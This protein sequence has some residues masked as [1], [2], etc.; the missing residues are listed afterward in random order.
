MKPG[1]KSQIIIL[2]GLK[3][4][5]LL[6]MGIAHGGIIIPLPRPEGLTS[7]NHSQASWKEEKTKK[8]S[9][10]TGKIQGN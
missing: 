6:A 1:K 7:N 8:T 2:Q 10:R 9:F 4:R 5:H 3:G